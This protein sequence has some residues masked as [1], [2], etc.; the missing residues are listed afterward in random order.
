GGIVATLI[1]FRTINKKKPSKLKVRGPMTDMAYGLLLGAGAMTV[2]FFVLLLT[3]QI[4]L[5]N[6][7]SNHQFSYYTLA[8][9]VMFI[10]VGFFEEMF[11]RG[12]VMQTMIERHNKRWLIYMVSAFVFGIA[13]ITNPNAEIIGVS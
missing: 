1:I 12:Y 5:A 2:I 3:N 9:A 6:A 4:T 8:F 13:H 11:F 10:L 7:L